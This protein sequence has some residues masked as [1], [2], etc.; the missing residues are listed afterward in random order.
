MGKADTLLAD[1]RYFSATNVAL[2]R[3]TE[4]MRMAENNTPVEHMVQ[5]LQTQAGRTAYALRKQTVEPVFGIAKSVLEFR[6]SS[7]RGLAKMSGEWAHVSGQESE[8]HGRI[9][10]EIRSMGLKCG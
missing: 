6:Q 3:F 8:T 7:F 2:A 1:T 4:Q 9:A 5:K 10:P